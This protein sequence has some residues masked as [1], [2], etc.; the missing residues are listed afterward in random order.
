V[1]GG[2]VLAEIT[3]RRPVVHWG[4]NSLFT[5]GTQDNAFDLFFEPVSD[6]T[7]DDLTRFAPTDFFPRKWHAGN[8]RTEDNA[9]WTGAGAQLDAIYLINRPEKVVV[10]DFYIS[11]ANVA[12]W[13]P[14]HH[15]LAAFSVSD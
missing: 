6:L 11:L 13:L 3:G 4:P 8:L 5:D 2:L 10:A 12:P 15:P 14:R 9:K 1:L 7:I